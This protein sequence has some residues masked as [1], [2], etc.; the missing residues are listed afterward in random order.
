MSDAGENVESPSA[1]M[2]SIVDGEPVE[3]TSGCDYQGYEFGANYLDSVCLEGYLWDADSGDACE[4][5]W[6]YTNG[7]DIPCPKCN[8]AEWL[9][10]H[11]ESYRDD[12]YVAVAERRWPFRKPRIPEG[13]KGDRLRVHWWQ[14]I[15]V[16]QAG[17]DAVRGKL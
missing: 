7:G 8:H 10:Y 15:G 16:A 4:G 13:V 14:L 6:M 17:W 2:Q 3:L 5:G 12:A 11:R 9:D 1:D